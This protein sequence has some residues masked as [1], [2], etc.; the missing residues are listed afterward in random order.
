MNTVEEIIDYFIAYQKMVESVDYEKKSQ[1]EKNALRLQYDEDARYYKSIGY[2]DAE[3]LHADVL[4]SFWII[5]KTLLLKDANWVSYKT[6]NFLNALKKYTKTKDQIQS[7][8]QSVSE[9]ASVCYSKGNFMLLP[10]G[11]RAM[12]NQRYQMTEDRMD[13][14]LYQCFGKGVLAKFF[15]SD[16][17]VR[18]WI[19]E[20]R[21]DV[22]FIDGDICPEKIDWMIDERKPK[23]ISE[24]SSEELKQ[25]LKR[26]TEKIKMRNELV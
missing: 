26:A 1:D 25:Y 24:M 5:Y 16:D 2:E 3:A 23:L 9:F 15:K 11:C 8:N 17:D 7:V 14:T 12:N 4:F 21:L 19:R 22:F 10:D 20:Q 18:K 6:L 13:V